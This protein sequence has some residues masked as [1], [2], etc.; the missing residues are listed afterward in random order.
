MP[1][2]HR[3]GEIA[4]GSQ[5]VNMAFAKQ[6]SPFDDLCD[7]L[8]KADALPL[9]FSAFSGALHR[10]KYAQWAIQTLQQGC[11]ARAGGGARIQPAFTRQPGHGLGKRHHAV[12][13]SLMRERMPGVAG[14]AED[15]VSGLI[16]P[17]ADPAQRPAAKALGHGDRLIRR[18]RPAIVRDPFRGQ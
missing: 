14:N 3:G 4:N 17:R 15:L 18:V 16:D 12:E 1:G 5:P 7:Q 10:S 6:I 11:P 8:F 2:I 9:T 13:R